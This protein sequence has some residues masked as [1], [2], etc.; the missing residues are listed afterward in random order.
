MLCFSTTVTVHRVGLLDLTSITDRTIPVTGDPF[1][2]TVAFSPR[3]W[4]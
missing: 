3:Y 4:A 1:N 2:I